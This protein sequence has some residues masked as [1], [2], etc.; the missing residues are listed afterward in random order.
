[1]ELRRD[2][3]P[4]CE[5]EAEGDCENGQEGEKCPDRREEAG[6][7]RAVGEDEPAVDE[8]FRGGR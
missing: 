2:G 3:I 1:V 8:A 5:D 6:G 7:L 4:E